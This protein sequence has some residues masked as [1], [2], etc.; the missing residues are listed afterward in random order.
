MYSRR[1]C[2]F[3]ISQFLWCLAAFGTL[4]RSVHKSSNIQFT[5][6]NQ[7][8]TDCTGAVLYS[9]YNLF[10][11]IVRTSLKKYQ[12]LQKKKFWKIFDQLKNGPM[13]C[14][15]GAFFDFWATDTLTYHFMACVLDPERVF[16]VCEGMLNPWIWWTKFR[17]AVV[18]V[19]VVVAVVAISEFGQFLRP[20]SEGPWKT[21]SQIKK[22][23]LGKTSASQIQKRVAQIQKWIFWPISE[24]ARCPFSYSTPT[25]PWNLGKCSGDGGR[26]KKWAQKCCETT[27]KKDTSHFQAFQ[28]LNNKNAIIRTE[29]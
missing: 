18:V 26:I 24:L 13:N 21:A 5:T 4:L 27:T 17:N 23:I 29:I 6:I 11:K 1:K 20:F 8:A 22:T 2:I 10:G 12:N 15:F 16:I 14:F 7:F 19:V 28:K 9:E 3:S 25:T